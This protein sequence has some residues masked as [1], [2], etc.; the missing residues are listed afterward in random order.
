[1]DK[2]LVWEIVKGVLVIIAVVF[3]LG[4]NFFYWLFR[5][6]Q[7]RRERKEKERKDRWMR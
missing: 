7:K 1:M 4:G 6:D 2:E 3:I 5:S